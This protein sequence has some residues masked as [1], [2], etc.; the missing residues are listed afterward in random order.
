MQN[1]DHFYFFWSV[2]C[3]VTDYGYGSVAHIYSYKTVD[4][5]V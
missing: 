2:V 3:N 4:E 5:I 1:A